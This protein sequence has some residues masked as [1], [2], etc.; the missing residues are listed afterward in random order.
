M[1]AILQ[2]LLEWGPGGLLAAFFG[3]MWLKER[4]ARDAAQ[5]RLN[6]LQEKRVGEAREDTQRITAALAGSSD[7]VETNTTAIA[8]LT[9]V[10][11]AGIS[12]GGSR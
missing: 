12:R 3:W 7:A 10:V 9:R 11:E 4:E 6:D 8:T 1:E 2:R 5:Q